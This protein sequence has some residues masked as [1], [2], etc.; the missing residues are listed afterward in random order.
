MTSN[1]PVRRGQVWRATTPRG[2]KH[3]FVVIEA[4]AAMSTYP[5]TVVTAVCDTSGTAPD[6]LLSAPI[7]QPVPATVIG[8]QLHTVTASFLSS[9]TYL[10]IVPPEE[11]EAVSRSI[12]L[13]LDLSD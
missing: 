6:T 10:G 11:M 12:R 13:S 7:E 8:T 2:L 5:H 3:T 4:D 1:P 9:G